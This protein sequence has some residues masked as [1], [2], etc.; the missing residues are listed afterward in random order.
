VLQP[1]PLRV[2]LGYVFRNPAWKPPEPAVPRQDKSGEGY[3][4]G[5]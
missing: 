5:S 2:R 3:P 1:N 4:L